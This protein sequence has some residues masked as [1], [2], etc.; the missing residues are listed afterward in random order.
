MKSLL[1][2]TFAL[3]AGLASRDAPAPALASPL[4]GSWTLVA[5]DKLLPDGTRVPD[6]GQSPRGRLIIDAQGRYSLQIFKAERL[7]FASGDKARASAEE[8]A[9]AALGSSTHYGTLDVDAVHGVLSFHI[10]GASF[11]NWEG[12]LQQRRY[13][14]EGDVL[15]YRVPP[16][17]DGSVPLSVWRRLE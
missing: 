8:Y 16:R 5:A 17:A 3:L 15:S 4:Q 13:S 10:E 7:H 9:A 2:M 12:T 1:G 6:Y 11:P 14:L